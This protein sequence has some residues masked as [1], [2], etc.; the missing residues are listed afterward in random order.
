MNYC[1]L[2]YSDEIEIFYRHGPVPCLNNVVYNTKKEAITCPQARVDLAVCCGCGHLF[3]ANFKSSLVSYDQRYDSSRAISQVYQR[4]EEELIRKL[5]SLVQINSK[6]IL[7]IGCGDG[8]FL[9]NLCQRSNSTGIGID[10]A[11]RGREQIDQVKFMEASVDEEFPPLKQKVNVVVLRHILEHLY[12]PAQFVDLILRKI[13]FERE[14]TLIAEVPDFSWIAHHGAFWDITYEHCNY[15]TKSVIRY[16]FQI[17][18]IDWNCSFTTFSKQYLL[19]VGKVRKSQMSRP[20]QQKLSLTRLKQVKKITDIFL[21]NARRKR[22]MMNASLEAIS[23]AF[24]IW[25]MSGKG[26]ILSN[27][28]SRKLRQK[29]PFV[30]DINSRKRGKFT[31]GT[32]KRICPPTVLQDS[33]VEDII[34]VNPQYYS[35]ISTMLKNINPSCNLILI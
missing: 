12:K 1:G 21:Q 30:I 26:V 3:N 9:V 16:L 6:T 8:H 32:G 24:S 35:E 20:K 19:A 7:E 29:I 27:L 34:V 22:S 33:T 15:F 31:P 23:G 2:C 13:D 4:Y 18:G 28:L 11:Y 10:P 5:S 17:E 25:G 14:V